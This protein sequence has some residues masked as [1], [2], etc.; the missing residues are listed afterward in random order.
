MKT[1]VFLIAAVT[2]LSSC[3]I[4]QKILYPTTDIKKNSD[5]E[6]STLIIDIEEFVDQR[7][8]DPEN[9][10]LFTNSKQAVIDRK[11]QCINSEKNYKN[12]TVTSQLT[13]MMVN[14]MNSENSFMKVVMNKKDTADYYI[15]GSLKKFYGRQNYSTAAAVGAQFGLI[16]ALATSGAKTDGKIILEIN[17]L[18]IYNKNNEI[19]K[20]IGTFRKEY[21][22]EFPADA[23]CWC[24]FQNV[25]AKL[26]EY[27]AGLITTIDTEI[28]EIQK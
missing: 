15:T 14:H 4:N 18:T 1:R 11:S 9:E 5:Q 13:Q 10:I 24:I 28:K 27:F 16:G 2:V 21:V 20:K 17:D 8:E 3:T 26:K 12:Q 23:Y 6:L 7:K 25:N 19:V 22:G